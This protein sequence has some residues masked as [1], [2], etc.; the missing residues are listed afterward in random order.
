MRNKT[1]VIMG[2][3][4]AGWVSALYFLNKSEDLNLNLKIKLISSNDIEPIGVGEGTTP[5]FTGFIENLCKIDKKEFLKETK[6]SFKYGIK[7]DN[8]NFDD[9]YYY[10]LFS[11]STSYEISNKDLD[12]DFI[13]YAINE[14]LNI[15]QKILQKKLTGSSFDL[16]KN[17]K[18]S[19]NINS[20]YAYHFSANLI[21]PFLKKKCLEFE[22]FESMEETI[23]TINY[24]EEGFI[25][26][27]K[28][29]EDQKISG[30]FFVNCLGFKSTD[31]LNIEYFN[32]KNW[33]KYILNNSAFAIQV[34]NSPIEIIEPYTT[35][36][37]QEYGWSWKIPQYEKTGY[38]YVY[39]SDFIGDE[40]KLYDDLLKTYKI[41]EKDIFKT[42]VVKSKPYYNLKQL[43]KNCLSLGLA[44][45]FVEPLEATSI[46]MTL[47]GLNTF[48]EMIAN[49][50]ELDKKHIDIFNSKLEQNWEN[51]FKFIIFHYFTNNPIN[52]YWEHYQ[53]IQENNIFD[54]YEKYYNN[55]NV[56]S[57]Y[58]YYR[59]S[60][61][62]KMKDFYY[63]FSQEKYLKENIH[64]Y[65][66]LETNIKCNSLYSHNEVLNE[67]NQNKTIKQLNYS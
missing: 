41:K 59:V 25:Q 18:I 17:N 30:D 63:N 42:K 48:F 28:T 5:I 23:K 65:L 29:K 6:G 14:E 9:E 24:N 43:H 20:A 12:Y 21:I 1:I 51:V 16:L 40:N 67:I 36:T 57:K 58:N 3:G 4:T 55:D 26:N 45:G 10:H 44:S 19:L 38:G 54:F 60:L 47:I 34:K 61:G 52:D 66:K 64:D 35:A 39:S 27:I 62:M 11:P 15:P 8:W 2:G 46:H 31:I 32:I 37:A 22:E 49:E 50:I 53:K 56:F 33:D 7:F 13:Q